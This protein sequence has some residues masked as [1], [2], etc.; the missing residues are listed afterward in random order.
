MPRLLCGRWCW[1]ENWPRKMPRCLA[2]ELFPL[3]YLRPAA[4]GPDLFPS[5]GKKLLRKTLCRQDLPTLQWMWWGGYSEILQT[6]FDFSWSLPTSTP[7]QRRKLGTWTTLPV[8]SVIWNWEDIDTWLK[9]NS[10]IVFLATWTSLPK[11]AK[12]AP[13]R[14]NRTRRDSTTRSTIGMPILIVSSEF[15]SFLRSIR[16]LKMCHL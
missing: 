3:C 16:I 14:L 15:I 6:F 11:F 8:T 13:R 7:G 5:R 10:H 12:P 1:S 2:S 9:T 4:G